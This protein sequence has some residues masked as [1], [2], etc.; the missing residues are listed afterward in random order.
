MLSGCYHAVVVG[1]CAISNGMNTSTFS[2]SKV[3]WLAGGIV[4]IS[5]VLLA[6]SV[7]A[8]HAWGNYH[9]GRTANP[10]SLSVGDN[11]SAVW[12]V[13]LAGAAADWSV[14][15]VLDTNVVAGNSTRNC[16]PTNGRVEVCNAKYGYNGWLGVAS[17]WANGDHIVQGTVKVNDTYFNTAK[18]NTPAWRNFVMC[19]EIGHTLGLDHQDEDFGNPNLDTCMDYTS[20][21][22]SNQHPNQ[23]DYDE[24]EAIYFHLDSVNTFSNLSLLA[25]NAGGSE[26]AEW[27]KAIR[28]STDG[29]PSLYVRDLSNG[30]KVFTFVI[31]AD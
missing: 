7:Y 30:Q 4:A 12:D 27:G 9:W 3:G 10:F 26:H 14:S 25:G 24:L 31:W 29:R 23:H 15:D 1:A 11:V 2:F 8:F 16:R 5:L 28:H 18:Y 6:G 21:P 13:S 20:A 22:D 19:Q 17:I